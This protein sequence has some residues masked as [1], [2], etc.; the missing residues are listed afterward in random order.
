MQIRESYKREFL[1]SL[2]ESPAWDLFTTQMLRYMHF[3][4]DDVKFM[5]NGVAYKTQLIKEYM[6]SYSQ[7]LKQ[8]QAY[9]IRLDCNGVK[10][11]PT[12]CLI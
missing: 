11:K 6:D 12:N 8:G 5:M 9:L 1:E 2:R 3:I 10:I 4:Q 7:L